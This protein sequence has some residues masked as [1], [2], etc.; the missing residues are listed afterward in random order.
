MVHSASRCTYGV[1]RIHAELRRLERRGN[2]KRV[3]RIMR[4]ARHRR[5]TRR[6]RRSLTRPAR[7]A[8]PAVDLIGRDGT[9]EGPGRKPVGDITHLPTAEGLLCRATRLDL[10]THGIVG[11]PMAEGRLPPP[12]RMFEC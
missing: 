1:A 12:R 7:R 9:A 2:R 11:H 8:V 3:E 5:G 6:K 10:A 4:G